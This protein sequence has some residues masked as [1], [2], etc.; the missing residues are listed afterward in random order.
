[1]LTWLVGDRRQPLPYRAYMATE[2]ELRSDLGLVYRSMQ[3]HEDAALSGLLWSKAIL[4]RCLLGKHDLLP[5]KIGSWLFTTSMCI[6]WCT[7]APVAH[8]C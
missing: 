8:G 7:E 5:A 3:A 6:R 4:L 1:L 2:A